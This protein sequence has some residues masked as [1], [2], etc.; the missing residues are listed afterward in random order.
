MYNNSV[1]YSEKKQYM[2]ITEIEVA[3][4]IAVEANMA[5]FYL[6]RGDWS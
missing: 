6:R 1:P 4:R 5:V 3:G 2:S